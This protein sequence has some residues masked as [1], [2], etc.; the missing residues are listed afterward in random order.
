MM[1]FE[2]SIMQDLRSTLVS[3]VNVSFQLEQGESSKKTLSLHLYWKLVINTTVR[4]R[5]SKYQ[6]FQSL[7]LSLRQ[8][9]APFPSGMLLKYFLLNSNPTLPFTIAEKC[10]KEQSPLHPV[11][12]L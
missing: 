6:A 9:S 1:Q 5:L 4:L 10:K 8:Y 12:K 3:S 2:Q 11:W 7:T